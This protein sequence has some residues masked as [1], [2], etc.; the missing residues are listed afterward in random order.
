[1][2]PVRNMAAKCDGFWNERNCHH[3]ASQ[4][5]AADIREPGA[6]ESVR[7]H[8]DKIGPAQKAAREA[9]KDRPRPLVA[10]ESLPR[11]SLVTRRPAAFGNSRS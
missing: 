2:T 3:G 5:I 1:M 7:K 4:D 8:S 10:N 9:Q 11:R 6:F